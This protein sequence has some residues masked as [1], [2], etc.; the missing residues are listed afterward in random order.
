MLDREKNFDV[1]FGAS[2]EEDPK[3]GPEGK[4][5]NKKILF[6]LIALLLIIFLG[7]FLYKNF[8]KLDSNDDQ[9]VGMNQTFFLDL[10]EMTV[11]L[12]AGSEN[13]LAWLRIKVVLEVKGQK[14]YD[15]IQK[16]T[17]KIMDLFQTYL[18]ELKKS[19]LEGSFGIYKI[20]DEMIMRINIILAPAKIDNI[21]FQE[22]ILQGV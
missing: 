14:N 9:S 3:K 11:N 19:D 16:M 18:K 4:K 6:A 2:L 21:L 12:R 7:W 17:P 8:I 13:N 5:F 15:L 1:K 10:E 22:F 20:K